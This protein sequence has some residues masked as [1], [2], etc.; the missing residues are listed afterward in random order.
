MILR[1]GSSR[2]LSIEFL[3]LGV[4]EWLPQ[5]PCLSGDLLPVGTQSGVW[6]ILRTGVTPNS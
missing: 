3:L 6:L 2:M 5:V 4:G 1:M